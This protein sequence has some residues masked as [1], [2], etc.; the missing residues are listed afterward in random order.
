MI[1]TLHKGQKVSWNSSGGKSTGIVEEK[2]T[3]ATK[4]KGH[5]AKASKEN[6]QF[7]VKSNKSGKEAIHKIDELKKV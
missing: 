5:T 7:K 1:K 2:L 6:P 3:Q 4:I